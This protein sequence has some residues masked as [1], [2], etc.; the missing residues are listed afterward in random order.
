MDQAI[1]YLMD[2]LRWCLIVVLTFVYPE[3]FTAW[4]GKAVEVVRPDEIKVDRRGRT[5]NV[6]LYG[7]DSPLPDSKQGFGKEAS[8]YT[9]QRVLGKAVEVQPLPGRVEGPWY[10][11]K[12]HVLDRY[13]R[14]IALVSIYGEDGPNLNEELLSKGMAWWYE[15]FVPF[16]RGLKALEDKAKSQKQGLWALEDPEPPWRYQHTTLEQLVP[17]SLQ[18]VIYAVPLVILPLLLVMF[19]VAALLRKKVPKRRG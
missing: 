18:R 6:R 5:E 15:P 10:R 9:E 1:G 12:V 4:T 11:P 2:F 19:V 8:A 3:S 14:F 13:D 17:T 16:E 7:I